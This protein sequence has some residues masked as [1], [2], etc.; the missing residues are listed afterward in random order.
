MADSL[1]LPQVDYTS[2]DYASIRDDLIGLIP[3]F[4]PQWTSRDSTDFGIVLIEL[5]AYLGDLVNYQIDRAANE[6]FLQTATQRDTVLNIAKLLGYV[7]AS[8]SPATGVVTFSNYSTTTQST[9]DKGTVLTTTA[10]ATGGTISFT[11]DDDVFLNVATSNTV[12]FKALGA[13]TQGNLVSNEQLTSASDGTASQTYAL[14]QLNVIPSITDLSITVGSV[15]YT[16]IDYLI[17]A[18]PNDPSYSS[19]TDGTGTTYIQ[20]GDGVSGRI[21]PL[22]SIIKAS[23]RYTTTDPVL[24]NIAAKTLTTIDSATVTGALPTVSNAAAFSGGAGEESTDSIR[25]NAPKALRARNRAVSLADYSAIALNTDGIAKATAVSNSY[26]N[27]TIYVAAKGGTTL[28]T[29]LANSVSSNFTNKTPPGTSISVK[30]FTSVYPYLNVTVTV[31]PQ[32]NATNVQ[33]AVSNALYSLFNIDNVDFGER[34]TEGDIYST[35]KSVEGVMYVTVNDYE[36]IIA[37]PYSTNKIYS[38]S[39][40]IDSTTGTSSTTSVVLQTGNANIFLGSVITS[41]N[42]STSHDAV[43]KTIT[44]IG[45]SGLTLTLSASTTFGTNDLGKAIVVQGANGTTP[46]S[47]DLSCAFNEIPILETS[48]ITVNTSGGAS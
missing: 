23:Y 44:A 24:G 26:S 33:T 15:Q 20:F 2:R 36:K 5:F 16:K 34:I 17:D 13:V 28:S 1:Y 14:A 10:D 21:P 47:R 29:S 32:Y 48:Y 18:G 8:I 3:N 4:T 11:L 22:G 12:P 9:I 30:D 25:V 40:L 45:N 35:C 7:P 42:G 39:A 27:V 37:N 31:L 43:G 38:Q 6:S 46:G 41:V 19:F